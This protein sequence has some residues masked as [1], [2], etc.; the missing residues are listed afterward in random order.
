MDG[1]AVKPVAAGVNRWTI[2]VNRQSSIVAIFREPLVGSTGNHILCRDVDPVT[3][4]D[5]L[6]PSF[7]AGT[8]SQIVGGVRIEPAQQKANQIPGESQVHIPLK[9][10]ANGTLRIS[11]VEVP[12]A[13]LSLERQSSS[14]RR[15]DCRQLTEIANHGYADAS[16]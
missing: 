1:K 3:R 12:S 9:A 6:R 16:R 15:L 2:A 10:P 8:V 4:R 11:T 14:L 7:L 13:R 5:I